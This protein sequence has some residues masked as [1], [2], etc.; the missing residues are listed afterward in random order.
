MTADLSSGRYAWIWFYLGRDYIGEDEP[1]IK[2][3]TVE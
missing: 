1:M 2:T 3:F